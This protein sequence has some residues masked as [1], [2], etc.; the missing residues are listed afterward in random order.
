LQEVIIRELGYDGIPVITPT[1]GESAGYISKLGLIN[2]GKSIGKKDI[3][4]FFSRFWQGLTANE[5]IRQLVLSRRPYEVVKGSMDETYEKGLSEFCKIIANGKIRQG[6]LDFF[7][8]IMRVPINENQEKVNIGIVGEGYVRVHEPSNHYA[9]RHLEELGVV[10]VLPMAG[11]F[12][13]YSMENVTRKNLRLLLK[14]AKDLSHHLVLKSVKGFQHYLEHHVTKHVRP[15]LLFPEPSAREIVH[16]AS[17]FMDPRVSSEA[18]EGIG[19]AS[20][21]SKSERVHGILNLIPAHCM[22]GSA[23]Q[24]YLEKVHRKS[25]IPVLTIPLDGIY[26]KGFKA[27]L[28]VLVHKARLYKTACT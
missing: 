23:L 7:E 1:P 18:V 20:S 27:N 4:K 12:L 8:R 25:R 28:E 21:Y 19:M 24:C 17:K 13:N 9:I 16:E 6:A 10:T 14:S 3:A 26:D 2:G 15:F 22:A 5:A 11:S